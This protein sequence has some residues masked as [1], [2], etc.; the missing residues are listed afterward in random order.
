MEG[1]TLGAVVINKGA[2]GTKLTGAGAVKAVTVCASA[3]VSCKADIMNESNEITECVTVPADANDNLQLTLNTPSLRGSVPVH[4]KKS[5]ITV[6]DQKHTADIT[7]MKDEKDT[8]NPASITVNGANAVEIQRPSAVTVKGTVEMFKVTPGGA[9]S[10]ITGDGKVG[11]FNLSAPCTVDVASDELTLNTFNTSEPSVPS[12]VTI[13]KPVGVVDFMDNVKTAAL[14]LDNNVTIDSIVSGGGVSKPISELTLQGTG[15]VTKVESY[16]VDL[17]KPTASKH[18]TLT[19]NKNVT[20]NRVIN[21]GK[22]TVT[23]DGTNESYPAITM[24]QSITLS[25][26]AG[27]TYTPGPQGMA[28]FAGIVITPTYD[29]GTTGTPVV[30]TEH[31]AKAY[32]ELPPNLKKGK[33]T[34]TVNYGG[35]EASFGIDVVLNTS[36]LEV[37]IKNA[38]AL[39]E[40]FN[41]GTYVTTG[42]VNAIYTN[43]Y[44]VTVVTKQDL[45]DAIPT[46]EAIEAYTEQKEIT[47]AVKKLNSLCTAIKNEANNH[48]GTLKTDAE[49]M[50]EAMTTLTNTNV[51]DKL[52]Q[53]LT[54][55]SNLTG[56]SADITVAKNTGES[57]TENHTG[58]HT[59]TVTWASNKPHSIEVDATGKTLTVHQ[60][61]EEQ[62]VALTA[63]LHFINDKHQEITQTK[64]FPVKVASNIP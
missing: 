43:Q 5:G 40:N 50:S 18:L 24:V 27:R 21:L 13:K 29:D 7:F 31:N 63:T 9:D 59:V 32:V 48:K 28:A 4:I 3:T 34:A 16:G 37:A 23:V 56:I 17:A 64:V 42:N 53:P 30:L 25:N 1:H 14:T 11:A 15:T 8:I 38:Y 52:K 61:A 41:N 6:V 55:S 12:T 36:Q 60:G 57:S 20:V 54:N 33:A 45:Q 58:D 22:G 19:I 10:T 49:V 62:V 35:Q 26:T 39:L 51:G 44:L 46:S 47:D 2:D